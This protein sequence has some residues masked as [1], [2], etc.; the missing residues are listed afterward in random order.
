[1]A[2][3]GFLEAVPR[4]SAGRICQKQPCC[5][6]VLTRQNRHLKYLKLVDCVPERRDLQSERE[7][8]REKTAGQKL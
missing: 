1:M 5:L 8:E 3:A 4:N 2:P 7:E 6:T